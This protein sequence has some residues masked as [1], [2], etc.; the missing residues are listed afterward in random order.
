M[1]CWILCVFV[2]FYLRDGRASPGILGIH[3]KVWMPA[4]YCVYTIYF[5]ERCYITLHFING[6]LALDTY[7][8]NLIT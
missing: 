8:N 7:V 1:Y 6:S 3:G 5:V 4:P 2:L